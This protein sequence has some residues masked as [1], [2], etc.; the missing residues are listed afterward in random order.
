MSSTSGMRGDGKRFRKLGFSGYLGKPLHLSILYEM[1]CILWQ[2]IQNGTEPAQLISR[3]TVSEALAI[4][5][6]GTIVNQKVAKKLLEKSGCKVDVAENGKECVEMHEQFSYDIIFMD[7]QIPI[8]DGFEA[9]KAIRD[10]EVD[11]D[12][13]QVI[14]AMTANAIEG[15]RENC[16]NKGMDDYIFKPIDRDRLNT[17]LLKWHHQSTG[18]IKTHLPKSSVG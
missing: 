5:D 16:I 14:I 10:S 8:M 15:D 9:T 3:Y 2:H 1:P 13:Y 17:M 7:C 6:T 11:S 12:R 4:T 18:L